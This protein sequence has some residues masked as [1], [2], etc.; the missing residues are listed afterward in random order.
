MYFEKLIIGWIYLIALN[1]MELDITKNLTKISN[2]DWI[3]FSEH[4]LETV[5]SVWKR[6]EWLPVG[7]IVIPYDV[8]N[9]TIEEADVWD[10]YLYFVLPIIEKQHSG[11]AND[12]RMSLKSMTRTQRENL[13][14]IGIKWWVDRRIKE[15]EYYK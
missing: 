7:N 4:S 14:Y 2:K 10:R 9:T 6:K 8:Y 15:L 12:L 1:N 13:T 5:K 3:W 11:I